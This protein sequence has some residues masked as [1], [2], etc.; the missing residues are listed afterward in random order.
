LINLAFFH[1]F[2]HRVSF[3]QSD[4]GCG[5]EVSGWRQFHDFSHTLRIGKHVDV[6]STTEV[7]LS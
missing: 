3:F 7:L 4:A 2:D 5:E 1:W 6:I